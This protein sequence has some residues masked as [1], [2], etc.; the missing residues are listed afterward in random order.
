MQEL[1]VADIIPPTN[2]QRVHPGGFFWTVQRADRLNHVMSFVA[3]TRRLAVVASAVN[4]AEEFAERLTLSGVP[5][6][7]ATDVNNS[8]AYDAFKKSDGG[9]LVTTAEFVIAHG[10]LPVSMT[11]HL[12]ASSSVRDYTKRLEALPSSVHLT[13]IVPEDEKRAKSLRSHF[14]QD[15]GH[16]QAN[17]ISLV[18]LIDLTDSK[19]VAMVSTARRRF[20]LG[21]HDT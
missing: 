6:H 8:L 17:D 14:E 21:R 15:H 3:Q 20:P 19:S 1:I 11:V 12:R 10:P 13:F 16:G 2:V 9:T 5:I 7:Q 4:V 18:D